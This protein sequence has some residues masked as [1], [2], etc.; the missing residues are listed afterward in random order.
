MLAA[1]EKDGGAHVDAKLD[2]RYEMIEQGL[3]WAINVNPPHGLHSIIEPATNGHLASL[4]QMGWE[5]GR[6]HDLSRLARKGK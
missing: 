6:S 4:R 3:G 5:L 2:R 1:A